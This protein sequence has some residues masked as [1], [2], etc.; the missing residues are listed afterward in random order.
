MGVHRVAMK[1]PLL[2]LVPVV[3]ICIALHLAGEWITLDLAYRPTA[4][5]EGEI[6]RLLSCHFLHTNH[7]HLSLNLAALILMVHLLPVFRAVQEAFAL[8]F[9]SGLLICLI[10]YLIDG[11]DIQYVGLSGI[12]HSFIVMGALRLSGSQRVYGLLIAALA[13]VK[14][15]YEN[16]F[17]SSVSMAELIEASVAVESHGYGL[18]VGYLLAAG[19]LW[20]DSQRFKQHTV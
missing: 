10:Y 13:T 14:V 3:S 1:R 5:S 8:L 7:Y 11:R 15:V 6:W 18:I 4:V 19:L 12:L 20:R 17:G 16:L 2:F 9:T